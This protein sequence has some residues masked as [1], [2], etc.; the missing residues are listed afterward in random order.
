MEAVDLTR[1][2]EMRGRDGRRGGERERRRAGEREK[3]RDG[4]EG[5]QREGEREGGREGG[6]EGG[7]EAERDEGTSKR[8]QPIALGPRPHASCSSRAQSYRRTQKK[9]RRTKK[10][11]KGHQKL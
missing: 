6:K 7:R 4:G 9:T 8:K 3:R 10:T 1:E 5:R 11:V 2:R